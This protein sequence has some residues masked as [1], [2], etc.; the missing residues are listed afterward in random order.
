M[1]GNSGTAPAQTQAEI[2]AA[3]RAQNA[4]TNSAVWNAVKRVPGLIAGA[5]VDTANLLLGALAGRG[6]QGLSKKPVGGSESINE[7]FGLKKSDNT[8]Q[9][10]VEVVLGMMSPGGMAKAVIVPAFAIKKL[11]D[12]RKAEKLISSGNVEEAWKQHGIYKDPADDVLKAVLPDTGAKINPAA[13]AAGKIERQPPLFKNDL[14]WIGPTYGPKYG[15]VGTVQDLLEHPEL[16]NLAPDIGNILVQ[17]DPLRIGGAGYIPA[18]NKIMMGLQ[19][20]GDEDFTSILLHELQ[21]ALQEQYGMAMGGSP[22]DFYANKKAFDAALTTLYEAKKA[23][24][25]DPANPKIPESVRNIIEAY[26]DT[27]LDAQA[28]ATKNYNRLPGE[29][30]ARIV[31]RLY[32]DPASLAQ[33]PLALMNEE[34]LLRYGAGTTRELVPSALPAV[35]LAPEVQSI[36]SNVDILKDVVLKG[37]ANP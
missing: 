33:N 29:V 8:T 9:N 35:D 10:A 14:S 26:E 18:E 19:R 4:K 3:L 27:L 17:R 20:G 22:R 23:T 31:Q 7:A 2:V 30:E 12:V 25:P 15:P 34:L 36:L 6:L 1:A 13:E 16:Y 21:H 24:R 28:Q 5:G 37:K 11:G 32:E